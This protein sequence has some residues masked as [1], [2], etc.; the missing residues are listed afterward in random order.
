[1]FGST[2][3]FWLNRESQFRAALERGRSKSVL[4]ASSEWLKDLP[5]RWMVRRGIIQD[6]P[7]ASQVDG[8]LRFFGVATVEA[9]RATYGTPA[10]AFRGSQSFARKMG[11]VATWL[12][13]A[14]LEASR[15]ELP[16]WNASAF[17]KALPDL[18]R[19]TLEPDP[20]TFVSR[21]KAECGKHGVVVVFAPA[22][23]GC[24]VSGATRWLTPRKALLVLSLRHKSNDHLWFTFF[25]EA[26]HL[27]LHSKKM[28]F[29]D[30]L[31]GLPGHLE[32]EANA[33][34][35][36]VL[37]PEPFTAE[38]NSLRSRTD[39]I[40]MARRIGVHPGI[41][42]G[43]LQHD[44]VLGWGSF[45]DLKLRYDWASD[46]VSPGHAVG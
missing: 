16:S 26:G 23:P 25:H 33:F 13:S 10:A 2:P 20:A 28:T 18:R 44:R 1:M 32:E 15:A 9:W 46:E 3:D 37:I 36:E 19:L 11:P 30:G 43:R 41:L 4:A 42:V 12:R 5:I 34:A 6:G 17:K 40:E 38:L 45:N 14:E 22:P 7:A 31:E 39:V 24:P 29:V 35:R 8:C 21:L 27:L